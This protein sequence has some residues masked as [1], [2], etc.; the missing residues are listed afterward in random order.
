M[1]QNK[2][3]IKRLRSCLLTSVFKLHVRSSLLVVCFSRKLMLL[4]MTLIKRY[5][6]S[7]LE[8]TVT[9]VS[10]FSAAGRKYISV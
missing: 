9:H 4:M 8:V 5:L 7:V 3:P 2:R 10:S 6:S 1:S